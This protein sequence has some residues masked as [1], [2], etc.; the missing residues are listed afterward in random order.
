MRSAR[1]EL[2]VEH[3]VSALAALIGRPAGPDDRFGIAVSGGPDSMALLHLCATAFPGQVEAATVD[4]GFRPEAAQE[5]E[6]VAAFCR[7]RGIAHVILRPAEPITGTLQASARAARYDLLW[8]WCEERGLS[9]LCT[10]HHADDQLETVLMRLNRG[11]GV[12]GL[13]GI[14]ARQGRLIRPLLG[15]TRAELGGVVAEA[16]IP[17]VQ[18]PSNQDR[19]FDRVAM[20][21]A[22]RDATWL[23]PVAASASAAALADAEEALQWVTRTALARELRRE[24][25]G[26][27]LAQTAYPREIQR[28]MLLAALQTIDPVAAPRG[29]VIDQALVKLASGKSLVIGTV[30]CWGGACWTFRAA[31]PRRDAGSRKDRSQ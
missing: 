29:R 24:G 4:H 13:A 7:E 27:C 21:A 20:R 26:V 31:P 6:M 9:W 15:F 30:Q 8:C 18:D 12:A 22:L 19:R 5:A 28:R 16:G 10:A 14:R 25:E 23:D 1:A 3:F 17:S 2:P 11:S